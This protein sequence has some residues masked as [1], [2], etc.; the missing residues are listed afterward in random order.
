M[1]DGSENSPVWRVGLDKV[2]S[3]GNSGRNRRQ[4][5][6]LPYLRCQVGT[7]GE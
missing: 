6:F 7:L 1:T 2:L 4:V 3:V 5:F